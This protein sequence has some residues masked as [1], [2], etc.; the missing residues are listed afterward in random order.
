[1]V[2]LYLLPRTLIVFI[3]LCSV[4]V[5]LPSFQVYRRWCGGKWYCIKSRTYFAGNARVWVREPQWDQRV[6][7][8]EDYE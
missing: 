7:A 8:E 5:A 1:M 6:I 4:V 2:F 3:I